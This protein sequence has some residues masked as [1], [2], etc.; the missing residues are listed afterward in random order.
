M[1]FGRDECKWLGLDPFCK[2]VDPP[3]G[4]TWSVFFL[5]EGADDVHPPDGER[6]WGDETVQLFWLSMVEGTELLAF[7][8]FFHVLGTAS[9]DGR[10]VVACS[11]DFRGHCP[12]PRMVSAYPMVYLGQNILGLLVGDAPQ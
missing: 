12:C 11:Q 10:P 5:R 7:G 3:L 9:L 1:F 6:P 2:I 4:R 8:A